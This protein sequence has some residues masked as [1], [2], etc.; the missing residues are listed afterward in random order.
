MRHT[1]E[2]PAPNSRAAAAAARRQQ[3][4]EVAE[5]LFLESGYSKTSVSRIVKTAGVA[6][7]TFYL[8]FST[9]EEILLELRRGV[10]RRLR[11]AF[12]A[13]ASSDAPPDARL[14]MGFV[15]VAEEV[16]RNVPLLRQFRSAETAVQTEQ[17]VLDGRNSMAAPIAAL[18]DDGVAAGAFVVDSVPIAAHA[19]LSLVSDLVYTSAAYGEPAPIGSLVPT[20]TRLLLR[21]LGVAPLRIDELAPLEAP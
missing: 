10:L 16:V 17:V 2:V 15:A 7:G 9:K 19:V 21:S 1:T 5:Q 14:A 4:L 8:Y 12:K 13:A 18:L 3:L 11:R 6:Q 20:T